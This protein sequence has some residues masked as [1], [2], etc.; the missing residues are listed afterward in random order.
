MS[1]L[2]SL[3]EST[4][5]LVAGIPK[6]V[7]ISSSEPS[8]IYYTLDGED[9]D[10]SSLIYTDKIYLPTNN[11]NVTLKYMAYYD[12]KNSSVFEEKYESYFEKTF[13][14]RKGGEDGT[15]IFSG[16]EEILYYYNHEG[17][18]IAASSIPLEDLEITTSRTD[19]QGIPVGSTK[20][21]INFASRQIHRKFSVSSSPD[22][23]NFDRYAD[24][25]RIDGSTKEAVDA[26]VVSIVNR[27]YDNMSPRSSFYMESFD[28]ESNY[29][30][31]NLVN[32]V[33]N[34]FTGE[35][36]FNYFD[37]R[38]NRWIKSKQKVEPKTF[39]FSKVYSNGNSRV[40][41]WIKD[42]VMSKIR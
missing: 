21:F 30:N 1:I 20:S 10:E 4:D 5:Q 36:V 3:S 15:N 29:L 22:S 13:T 7:T 9:P 34:S 16:S 24:V 14:S 35:I 18:Q 32:Y 2:L 8:I 23:S 25:I 12:G 11:A 6:F 26:Q 17:N 31:G 39:D 37:S 28:R 40:F 33:Y 38:E 41:V 42:P 19:N 27:P